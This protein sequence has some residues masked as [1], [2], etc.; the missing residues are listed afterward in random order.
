MTAT[1]DFVLST[2]EFDLLQDSLGLGRAPFPLDVPSQGATMEERAGLAAQ[3]LNGLAARGLAVRD[4]LDE[5]LGALLRL[6]FEH[7]ISVDA[8]GHLDQPLRALAAADRG[9]GVLA[10]VTG[11]E[12]RLTEIRPTALARSIVD[13]LPPNDPGPVRSLSMPSE[14]LTR[15]VEAEDDE[16]DPFGGDLDDHTALTRAGLPSQDAATLIELVE[17]RR[18]GGQFGVTHGSARAST[19]VNWFDTHQGRYLMT[20]ENSW[21]SIT[22]ADNQRIEHRLASVVSTV[23]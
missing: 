17:N 7:D 23:S 1:P 2:A 8:V 12:V 21:L 11:D 13:V 18:A 6:L 20:S 3:A 14:P 10:E 15:A 4:E 22:P 19:L 9:L 5:R 16:D